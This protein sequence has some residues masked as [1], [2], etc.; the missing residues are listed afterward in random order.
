MA[1]SVGTPEPADGL[2]ALY[3]GAQALSHEAQLEVRDQAIAQ[4]GFAIATAETIAL[5]RSTAPAGIVEIGAGTGYWAHLLHRA[6]VD[7]LAFD[8]APPTT[9]GN[10]WFPTTSTWHHVEHAD[11]RVVAE[12]AT[13]TLLI[14]WPTKD[15][16]WPVETLDL[17]AAAGGMTVVYVGEHVGGRTGDDTF[18]AR[19]GELTT[20][21]QCGLGLVD[22][23]CVCDYPAQ[24]RRTAR[25]ELPRWPDCHDSLFIYRRLPQRRLRKWSGRGRTA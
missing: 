14:V 16:M 3:L 13:R 5:V 7:V 10:K 4:F 12:H 11:H 20:C 15:E 1:E 25:A 17:F 18:H 19:L 8:V 23:P 2:L 24:W 22:Q 6:G 9:G 21:R